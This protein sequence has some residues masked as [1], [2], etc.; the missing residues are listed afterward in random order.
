M[1]AK[2]VTPEEYQKKLVRYQKFAA[3]VHMGF[4]D[5]DMAEFIELKKWLRDNF[6]P[7]FVEL[8]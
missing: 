7:E 4:A 3:I 8:F 5:A 1:G 2:I 6:R